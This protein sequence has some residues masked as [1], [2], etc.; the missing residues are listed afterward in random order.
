GT[1]DASPIYVGGLFVGTTSYGKTI[2]IDAAS[3]KIRWV[4]TPAGYGSWA[5]RAQITTS[6]P[7]SDRGGRYVYAAAPDGRIYKLELQSGRQVWAVTISRLPAREKIGVALN[8]SRGL[9]L[10]ATGGYYG[11]AP[12]YQGHVAAIDAR[13]GRIAHIWNSLCSN[14]H[15]LLDPATSCRASDSAIWARSGVVV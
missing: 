2:A 4:F 8:F 6:P 12:P 14:R 3:G 9:V 11:D 5:A 15:E 7:V 13:T 10:A 1:V